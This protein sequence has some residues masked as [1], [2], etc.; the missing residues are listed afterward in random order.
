[1]ELSERAIQTFEKENFDHI[2]EHQ[3]PAG[4]VYPEHS[5]ASKHS[6]FVTDGSVT[7]DIGGQKRVITAPLRFDIPANTPHSAVVGPQG[8]IAIIAEMEN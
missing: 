3:D 5:H 4:T 1:M 8:W 7:F 2:Y 6:I